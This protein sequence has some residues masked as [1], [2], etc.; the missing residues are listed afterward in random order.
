M[1]EAGLFFS[2]FEEEWSREQHGNLS[3]EMENLSDSGPPLK[4]CVQF[5]TD[6]RYWFISRVLVPDS[7]NWLVNL[8]RKGK[9]GSRKI[10]SRFQVERSV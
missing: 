2:K 8:G 1:R 3:G 4:S 5:D 6:H 7:R 9:I 10:G